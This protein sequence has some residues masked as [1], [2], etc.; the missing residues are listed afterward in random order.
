[1]ACS[2][3]F[4][5]NY[6][7][8]D[9]IKVVSCSKDIF[10][11][12]GADPSYT[13]VYNLMFLGCRLKQ[14][15]EKA[16][17]IATDF[18]NTGTGHLLSISGLHVGALA[19]FVYFLLGGL[20][21]LLLG[22][23]DKRH[24][25]FFYVSMP[26]G[27]FIAT[28]YVCTIGI[29]VPRLRSLLMLGMAIIGFFVP[30]FKNKLNIVF[31]AA[32]I[33]LFVMPGSLFSYSFYY[34]FVAVFALIFCKP[35]GCLS[36]SFCVSLFLIP[37]SLHSSGGFNLLHI[38][39]NAL[40]IPIFSFFYFPVALLMTLLICFE[41]SWPVLILDQLTGALVWVI[42]KLSILSSS[43]QLKLAYLSVVEC[44]YLYAL[45]F[46]LKHLFDRPKQISTKRCFYIYGVVTLLVLVFVVG[47][48]PYFYRE[49]A[50]TNFYLDKGKRTNGSGDLVLGTIKGK[51]LAVDTGPGGW[52]TTNVLKE[53]SRKKIDAIDYLLLT[54]DHLDHIGGLKEL[55]K[56]VVVKVVVVPPF[57][58]KGI[59]GMGLK[60][61]VVI[62]C[63]N[64]TLKLENNDV[65]RFHTP[66]CRDHRSHQELS[67]S[68][69]TGAHLV[70]F[71]SDLKINASKK[72]LMDI[73]QYKRSFNLLQLSHHCS[74]YDNSS[75]A[76]NRF[77]P[78]IGFCNRHKSLFK[79]M[80][81]LK[82]LS[83]PVLV[84]ASCG[85]TKFSLEDSGIIV[86]S[87]K[88]SNLS[89]HTP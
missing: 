23:F 22:Y 26:L 76:L 4:A 40:V 6:G 63:N 80:L 59:L 72:V 33:V 58:L 65:V 88:C 5:Y 13:Y 35:K 74:I 82:K 47:F 57:M 87:K 62:A 1:M 81:D 14:M 2:I 17:R 71:L 21:Y 41:L 68:I 12:S 28:L 79:S 49:D 51:V 7:S 83:F 39:N 3:V 42:G 85:D 73:H 20:L 55:T 56:E 67:F 70:A 78:G 61:E 60:S 89:L 30:F 25:P 66:S 11:Q 69:D 50:I 31:I 54:H 38:F 19:L 48:S 32:A 64:S 29:E 43:F 34:S 24:F 15:P 75:V 10:A 77:S 46:F 36:A 27:F 45:L 9:K 52:A 53:I 16:K 18:Y 44:L 86:S 37:L 84:G 8:E